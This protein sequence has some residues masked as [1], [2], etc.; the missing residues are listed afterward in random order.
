MVR[1]SDIISYKKVSSL[2]FCQT[3]SSEDVEVVSWRLNKFFAV[4]Y[5]ISNNLWFVLYDLCS[6][7]IRFW[8]KVG[9]SGFGFRQWPRFCLIARSETRIPGNMATNTN[10]ITDA[11]T[12]KFETQIQPQWPR[13]W[14]WPQGQIEDHVA[15]FVAPCVTVPFSVR[16]GEFMSGLI[17][18]GG[19]FFYSGGTYFNSGG[20]LFLTRKMLKIIPGG[21]SP[22]EQKRAFY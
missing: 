17:F 20:P 15:T 19:A 8:V 16:G 7:L 1:K 4:F 12:Y 10:S 22:P 9:K 5:L 14:N 2:I 6:Y 13:S 18:R 21:V 11:N 3:K